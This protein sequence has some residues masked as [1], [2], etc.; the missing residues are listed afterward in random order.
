MTAS[1]IE[2]GIYPAVPFREYQAIPALNFST[3]KLMAEAPAKAKWKMDHPDEPT[4]EMEFGTWFHSAALQPEE[5]PRFVQQPDTYVSPDGPKKWTY[6]ARYC[7]DWCR[8][9]ESEGRTV[10]TRDALEALRG[11]RRAI[12]SHPYCGSVL[13]TAGPEDRELVC[14]QW[15]D[16]VWKW[17]PHRLVKCRIDLR[18]RTNTLDDYKS[19]RDATPEAFAKVIADRHYHAQAR[20]YLDIH[21]SLVPDREKRTCFTIVAVEKDP[22]HLVQPY[23][24]GARSME[25][26]A[27][28]VRCWLL[29]YDLCER[30]GDWPGL[31]DEPQQID[32][33]EWKLRRVQ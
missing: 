23:Y 16:H 9:H 1:A 15:A 25:D 28:L 22:P 21:N 3:L 4:P 8:K 13:K 14:I 19:C 24:L 6:S 7:K 20:W 11:M 2:P 18:P 31:G 30:S 5:L 33:P 10:V 17:A 12:V 26:A 29:T 27:R 32:L